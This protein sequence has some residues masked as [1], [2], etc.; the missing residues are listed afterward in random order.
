MLAGL[1]V[2]CSCVSSGIVLVILDGLYCCS[3]D[4]AFFKPDKQPDKIQKVTTACPYKS[5]V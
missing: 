1:Y 2:L 3:K 4:P 5:K